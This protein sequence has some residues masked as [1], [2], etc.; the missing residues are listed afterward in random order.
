[1]TTLICLVTKL[2]VCGDLAAFLTVI[3][4]VVCLSSLTNRCGI[5]EGLEV[6]VF[7][8]EM[9]SAYSVAWSV[10]LTCDLSYWELAMLIQG[11][12]RPAIS[13]M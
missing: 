5:T 10:I 12:S 11:R 1:M 4:T 13:N 6:F 8:R 3:I 2:K 7:I 9:Q